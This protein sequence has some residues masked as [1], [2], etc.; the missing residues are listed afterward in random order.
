MDSLLK[1]TEELGCELA[2]VETDDLSS[3]AGLHTH[4]LNIAEQADRLAGDSNSDAMTTVHEA[5]TK[6]AELIENVI[7]SEADD[8]DAALEAVAKT[9][10]SIQ[11]LIVKVLRGESL[12]GVTFPEEL[13]LSE[14]FARLIVRRAAEEAKKVS[15]RAAQ[16]AARKKAE[17]DAPKAEQ[18][19]AASDEQAD[20][21][22]EGAPAVSDE[23]ADG[24][25]EGAPAV[26]DE[27]ADGE[28]EG[29]PAAQ[30]PTEDSADTLVKQVEPEVPQAPAVD[31]DQR[32]APR[33]QSNGQG[34]AQDDL[35]DQNQP[36]DAK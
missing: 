32:A 35:A 33:A 19:P 1:L 13:G 16:E 6:A 8:D 36:Q 34:D 14:E 26:S 31:R 20:G 25:A 30:A 11:Q 15:E 28:A 10:E 29:A 4:L 24:E 23:Q 17:Q 9:A 22:A 27:Q 21:E 5:G 3:L 12:N 7:L 2:T 18:P